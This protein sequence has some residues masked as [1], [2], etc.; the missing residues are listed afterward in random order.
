MAPPTNAEQ[1]EG[2]GEEALEGQREEKEEELSSEQKR[3]RTLIGDSIN[4]KLQQLQVESVV[5][6]NIINIIPQG[7]TA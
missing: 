7:R 5:V 6:Y 1:G 3:L 2:E 4:E